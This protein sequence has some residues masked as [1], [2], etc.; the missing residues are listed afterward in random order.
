[1]KGWPKALAS[2]SV[3]NLASMSGELPAGKPTMMR[4]GLVG[5][6]GTGDTAGAAAAEAFLDCAKLVDR[7]A[8]SKVEAANP[9]NNWR[10]K[11][12]DFLFILIEFLL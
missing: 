1:M 12:I 7:L 8:G 11:S 5:Q 9:A 10:R 2:G 4:T 3:S 6:A